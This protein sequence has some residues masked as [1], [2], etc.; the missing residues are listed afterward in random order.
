MLIVLS[1]DWPLWTEF[2]FP[3]AHLNVVAKVQRIHWFFAF[4]EMADIKVGQRMVDKSMHGAIRAVHVLVDHPRDEVWREGDDKCLGVVVWEVEGGEGVQRLWTYMGLQNVKT[5][6][7]GIYQHA[8][9]SWNETI[10]WTVVVE[11]KMFHHSCK[12]L[13]HI[14]YPKHS[15]QQAVIYL[16]LS[17]LSI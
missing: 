16:F 17:P 6:R 8:V 9:S 3:P 5:R 2:D 15:S 4:L 1:W 11:L 7:R 13:L 14:L 12:R 10:H